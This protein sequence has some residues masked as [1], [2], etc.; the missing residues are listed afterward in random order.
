[1][2]LNL[3]PTFDPFQ[4]GEHVIPF[5]SFIFNGGEPYIKIKPFADVTETVT[6]THRV[7]NFADMGLLLVAV[8]ALRNMGAK[9]V[10]IIFTLFPRRTSRPFDGS[11]GA[12]DRQG[13][14]TADQ[15]VATRAG[16]CFDPHSEVTPALLDNCQV[17]DNHSFVQDVCAELSDDLLL[18]SPDGGALKKIYKTA[19]FLGGKY[20]VIECSKSRDVKTGSSVGFQVYADDLQGRDC[21]IV[22]DIC[23]GGGTFN[24]LAQALKDKNAGKLYLA[25]SH[26]I[27][28]KG[29][30]TLSQYFEK[31]YHR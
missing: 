2:Y 29:F 15:S 25:I 6:V 1:M 20:P 11:R 9:A 4:A 8:D 23:D 19:A 18:I 24:G 28:S 13:V 30:E 27:F 5:E 17:V 22:D 12:I 3:D 16:D 14:C 31:F 21:L 26:G 7:H 10:E